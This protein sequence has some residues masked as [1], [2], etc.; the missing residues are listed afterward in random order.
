M[1][2]ILKRTFH[3]NKQDDFIALCDLLKCIGLAASGG[4][5]KQI[6]AQGLVQVDGHVE[7]RKTCKIRHNQCVMVSGVTVQV[8]ANVYE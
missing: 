4:Q 6:I 8:L 1:D 2:K 3:L 7:M 5:A